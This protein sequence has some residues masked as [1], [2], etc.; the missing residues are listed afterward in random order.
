[1]PS[2]ERCRPGPPCS[3]FEHEADVDAGGGRRG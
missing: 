3:S 1:V 2:V